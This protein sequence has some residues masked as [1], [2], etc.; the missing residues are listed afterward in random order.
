MSASNENKIGQSAPKT[1]H[2]AQQRKEERRSNFLYGAIAVVFVIVA[3]ATIVWRSNIIART[4]TAATIDGE[5]YNAAEVSFFYQNAYRNFYNQYYYYMAY[6]M[7]SLNTQTD[8]KEQEITESDA[9]MLGVDAG[10]TWHD[11]FVDMGLKQMA[12]V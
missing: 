8:L 10:Q 12:A 3:L 6:G 9:S 1:A 5:K 7:L 11:F 4:A 2:E